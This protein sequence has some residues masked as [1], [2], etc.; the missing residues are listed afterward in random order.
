[1]RLSL[2][3]SSKSID[4]F[5]WAGLAASLFLIT[6]VFTVP[7]ISSQQ[8]FLGGDINDGFY[9][10][11]LQVTEAFQRSP[12][13]AFQLIFQSLTEDY[14]RLFSLP[15]VPF[16][17]ILGDSF[18]AYVISLAIVYLLPFCLTLGAIATTLIP[19]YPKAVFSSTV[20]IAALFTPNWITLLQGYPDISAA[21]MV[22]LGIWVALRGVERK[23]T[24]LLPDRW[25]VPVLGFLFG[26]GILLRRHFAYAIVAVLGAVCIHTAVVFFLELRRAPRIAWRNLLTFVI[27]I[28]LVIATSAITLLTLAWEFTIRAFTEN[29]VTLYDSWSRPIEEVFQFYGELYGWFVWLL[30]FVGFIAGVL[31][32]SLSLPAAL[33]INSFGFISILIWLFRLRYNETYYALHFAPFILLGLAAFVWTVLLNLGGSKRWLILILFGILMSWNAIVSITPLSHLNSP[34]RP[35][36]AAAYPPPVRQNYGDVLQVMEF[37]RQTAPNGEPIFVVYTG[38]LPMHLILSAERTVYGEAGRL[39]QMKQGSPTDSDGFYP[40]AELLAAEY[41]VVT[42]PFV[43]W[44][45]PEQQAIQ[46]VHTAFNEGWEFTEDFAPLPQQFDLQNG[47]TTTIYQ[48]IRPTP[49]DRAVRFFHALQTQVNKPL[50]MQPD[51]IALSQNASAQQVKRRRYSLNSQPPRIP[52]AEPAPSQTFLYVGNLAEQNAIK[53]RVIVP[54]TCE[55]T[56]LEFVG[57][58]E[59]G[60][61]VNRLEPLQFT[62]NTRLRQDL[63]LSGASYLALEISNA[64][65]NSGEANQCSTGINNLVVSSQ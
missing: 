9:Q 11:T 4:G 27:R 23:F 29:Y 60:Q 21:L 39:L 25:Q 41:V 20:L 40:I 24:W 31:T 44:N 63:N 26:I 35:L 10:F 53:G 2:P 55:S 5:F 64:A 12:I 28:S 18:L 13:E 50:G 57:L 48:R 22:V 17:L 59:Q 32:R 7:Y 6:L 46:A 58:N 14:N 62:E 8:A 33:F 19:S 30:V 65:W 43:G 42:E 1:M 37:L 54:S 34:L 15:L 51:W 38:H 16:I 45:E 3:S 47:V 61:I 36:F 56:T 52:S 49:A